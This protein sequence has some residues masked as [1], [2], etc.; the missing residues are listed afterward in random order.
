VRGSKSGPITNMATVTAAQGDFNPAN[1]SVVLI[2]DVL[3]PSLTA[4]RNG[5]DVT[6][7]WAASASGFVLQQADDLAA[8]V[9]TDVT[10][11]PTIV[12]NQKRVTLRA[13]DTCKCY[14]LRKP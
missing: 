7:S 5:A 2:T 4:V 12:G 11:Q 14:R 8:P 10:T 13:A 9:W 6:L 3:A 1:N